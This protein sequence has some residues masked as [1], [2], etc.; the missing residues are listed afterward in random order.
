MDWNGLEKHRIDLKLPLLII[1][2][3]RGLLACGYLNVETFDKTGETAAIVTG[4]KNF[5]DML[6]AKAVKVSNAAEQAGIE[7]GMTGAEVVERI[8]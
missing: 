1:S 6:N 3:T 7:P 5:D 2:G 4:V 8:R